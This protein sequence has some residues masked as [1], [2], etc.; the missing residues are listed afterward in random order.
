MCSVFSKDSPKSP[1]QTFDPCLKILEI[2]RDH[3]YASRTWLHNKGDA[4][5]LRNPGDHSGQ[6][7]FS[8]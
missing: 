5:K 6:T 2:R 1:A 8:S 3:T 4:K 7:V